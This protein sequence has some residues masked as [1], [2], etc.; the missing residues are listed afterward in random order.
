MGIVN[1]MLLQNYSTALNQIDALEAGIKKALEDFKALKEGELSIDQL[2]I[3]ETGWEF[4]PSAPVKLHS[5]GAKDK[6][7]D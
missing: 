2:A 5:N 1:Q 3:S 4:Q 6:A 7:D